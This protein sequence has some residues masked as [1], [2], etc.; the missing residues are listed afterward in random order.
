MDLRN[1]DHP[2]M[3]RQRLPAAN[4]LIH[5]R[6]SSG[7]LARSSPI[8]TRAVGFDGLVALYCS[9]SWVLSIFRTL[10]PVTHWSRV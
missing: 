9:Q 4:G 3:S 8:Q 7:S 6:P 10:D 5:P 2:A 1:V